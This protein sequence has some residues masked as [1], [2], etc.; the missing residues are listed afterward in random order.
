EHNYQLEQA[1]SEAPIILTP[2]CVGRVPKS[3]AN[4]TVNGLETP[5]WVEMTFGFN[6]SR[7]PAASVHAGLNAEGLPVGLQVIGRQRRDMETLAAAGH[8]ETILGGPG[9]AA[10]P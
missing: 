1:F 8:I 4:G 2:T 10:S 6:M 3:C 7:N 9:R 5:G